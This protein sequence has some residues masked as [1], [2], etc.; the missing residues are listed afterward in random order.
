MAK[1]FT[2]LISITWWQTAMVKVCKAFTSRCLHNG[3]QHKS[4]LSTLESAI[5]IPFCFPAFI[6]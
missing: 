3:L 1:R 2:A 5:Q 4:A 6:C